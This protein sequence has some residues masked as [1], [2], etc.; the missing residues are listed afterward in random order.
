MIFQGCDCTSVDRSM[1][2]ICRGQGMQHV[3]CVEF[4]SVEETGGVNLQKTFNE[5][6]SRHCLQSL[7]E[8]K[9]R[10]STQHQHL[11]VVS[12]KTVNRFARFLLLCTFLQKLFQSNFC[13][14]SPKQLHALKNIIFIFVFILFIECCDGQ[15]LLMQCIPD[16]KQC[17]TDERF[18]CFGCC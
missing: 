10:C 8:P 13:M 3:L 7:R 2:G 9:A 1:C 11:T 18:S 5:S 12:Y 17:L 16:I 6:K 4:I 15:R 14:L